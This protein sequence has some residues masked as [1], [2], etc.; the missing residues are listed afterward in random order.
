MDRDVIYYKEVD[1]TNTKIKEFAKTGKEGL[2]VVADKQTAGR[3]RRG[4]TWE[5]TGD[6]NLY[7]SVLLKPKLEITKAAML[8]LVMA[9][10]VAKAL[11]RWEIDVQIK[12]PNDLI[13]GKKKICGI[14]TEM[15]VIDGQIDFIVVG[16]GLN[17]GQQ[18]FS[19]ELKEKATSI[20]TETGRRIDR[21]QVLSAIMDVFEETYGYFLEN[22]S[23]EFL[24]QDYND[25][26]VNMNRQVVVL[27][28]AGEYEGL[29]QGINANG[30]LQ[31]LGADGT[32][33]SVF[34]GEVSVRGIY[35]Y[36]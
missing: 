13:M 1:S 26:L 18:V 20:F 16:V 15:E 2:V 22:K 14:L 10:S 36:V 27:D 33:T 17:L 23:L 6:G 12:W 31:V 7:M 9:Y 28:P 4:R 25:L 29:A 35:G 24:M 3:G 30:E 5:S 8:T 34:A 11:Q 19:E 32:T 21:E